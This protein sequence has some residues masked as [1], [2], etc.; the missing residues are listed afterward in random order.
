LSLII[1]TPP[2]SEPIANDTSGNINDTETQTFIIND[3]QAPNVTDLT[4]FNGTSFDTL[5]TIEIGANITD[6]INMSTS[7]GSVSINI[8]L[9][10]TS[11]VQINLTNTSQFYNTSFTI[12]DLT[13][14]YTVRFFANDTFNN[15]NS[16]ETLFF[17]TTDNFAPQV[18]ILTPTNG[19]TYNVTET[20]TFD[21]N[22]TDTV[23]I[24]TVLLNITKPDGTSQL[25]TLTLN[26]TPFFEFNYTN[27]TTS[28]TVFPSV[29]RV[30][31]AVSESLT[32]SEVSLAVRSMV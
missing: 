31:K 26:S 8:T 13:G 28:K 17:L 3:D 29:M 30:M 7:A 5:I 22:I 23:G 1:Q 10:N 24:D 27:T 14:T 32:L 2:Q 19:T 18:I 16:T 25:E 11:I 6:N 12:P 15:I 20:T 21:I 9:P 4:P